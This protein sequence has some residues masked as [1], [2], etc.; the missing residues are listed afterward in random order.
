[1]TR[2][3]SCGREFSTW[4]PWRTQCDVCQEKRAADTNI[5]VL[6]LAENELEANIWRDVLLQEGIPSLTRERDAMRGR[7]QTAP[8][9]FSVEV[10][11]KQS[12]LAVARELIRLDDEE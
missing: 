8:Q 6:G 5:V 10:L 3:C 4:N 2:V 12:D 7:F 1:M 9:P 11:V